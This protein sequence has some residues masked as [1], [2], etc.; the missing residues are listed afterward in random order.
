MKLIL[1]FFLFFFFAEGIVAQEKNIKEIISTRMKSRDYWFPDSLLSNPEFQRRVIPKLEIVSKNILTYPHDKRDKYYSALVDLYY[2]D[3][4]PKSHQK[5]V[6][7]LMLGALDKSEWLRLHNMH[8]LVR[9]AHKEDFNAMRLNMLKALILHPTLHTTLLFPLVGKLDWSDGDEIMRNFFSQGPE[10]LPEDENR[11]GG[12]LASPKWRAA[13]ALAKKGDHQA[14]NYLIIKAKKEENRD[15]LYDIFSD[16]AFIRTR[17]S[18]DFLID[19]LFSDYGKQ[20]VGHAL[21][22]TDFSASSMELAK[23]IKGFDEILSAGA[24]D[25][26]IIRSW[27]QERKRTY[28]MLPEK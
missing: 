1:V 24:Y 20:Q 12:Y 9:L 2:Y 19:F 7:L 3:S 23:L 25:E 11:P 5:I 26:K 16:F 13:I 22:H 15:V 10:M 28:E 8:D 27:M 14:M 18:T 17:E 4:K 6:E 21:H